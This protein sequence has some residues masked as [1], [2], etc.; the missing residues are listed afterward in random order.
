MNTLK[1]NNISNTINNIVLPWIK[2]LENIRGYGAHTLDAYKRDVVEF[3]KAMY[4]HPLTD[5]GLADFLSDWKKTG[6]SIL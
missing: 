1:Q 3:L 2:Y 4:N 6:Q 5:K